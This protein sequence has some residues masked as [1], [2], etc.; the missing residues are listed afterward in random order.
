MYYQS[1]INH[2][3]HQRASCTIELSTVISSSWAILKNNQ[4]VFWGLLY[5]HPVHFN[6]SVWCQHLRNF[7]RSFRLRLVVQAP[8]ECCPAIHLLM[9]LSSLQ[10][11]HHLVIVSVPV[12]VIK[13]PVTPSENFKS[14]GKKW[15]TAEMGGGGKNLLCVHCSC[16]LNTF[17]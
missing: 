7:S 8:Q 16:V 15:G 2:S 5:S 13:S 14:V 3:P 11:R 10:R 9:G 12:S 17:I 6:V 4:I 1:T